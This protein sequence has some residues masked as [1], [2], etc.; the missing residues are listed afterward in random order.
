MSVVR[1]PSIVMTVV[2]SRVVISSIMCCSPFMSSVSDILL[3]LLYI[4]MTVCVGLLVWICIMVVWTLGIVMS[5]IFIVLMFVFM[6][7]RLRP[8]RVSWDGVVDWVCVYI[9]LEVG[10]C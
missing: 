5:S 8:C 9:V 4:L 7:I 6:Y 3:G 1:S 10:I 2:G